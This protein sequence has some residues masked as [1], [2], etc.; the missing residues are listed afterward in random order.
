[1]RFLCLAALLFAFA[2]TSS[3]AQDRDRVHVEATRAGT[4]VAI[5]ARA[6]LNAPY[7]LIWS[8]LTDY[9]HLARFIPGIRNS[10]VLESRGRTT[11]VEQEGEAG[12]WIFT[13][14]I[15]V[16]VASREEPPG[17][18]GIRLIKGNLKQL[19]G[20]YRI[21]KLGT[22]KDAFELRWQGVIEPSI[23]LPLFLTVPLMRANIADQFRSMVDEIERRDTLLTAQRPR[24]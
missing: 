8:T 16:V 1:M 10:H 12:F 17:F 13:Y 5:K 7:A 20:G 23:S 4:A 24:E 14:P 19:S 9:D 11:I 22:G 3:L 15:H 18:I 2:A 6:T 21:E